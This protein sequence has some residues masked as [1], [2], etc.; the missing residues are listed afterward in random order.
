MAW[1]EPI[2]SFASG[3]LGAGGQHATNKAN[4]AI[5]REQMAFQERMSSTAAQRAVADYRAAGLN[6]ALAYDRGASS[7]SGASA[8][9]GNVAEAGTSSAKQT[10]Q[11]TQAMRLAAEEAQRAK[12]KHKSDQNLTSALT[13]KAVA[14]TGNTVQNTR[15]AAETEKRLQAEVARLMQDTKFA[16]ARQPYDVQL[17]K[18]QALLA[19]LQIPGAR[20]TAGFEE[21]MGRSGKGIS[22]ARS[23]AEI[24]KL[25]R[26]S[27]RD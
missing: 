16:M 9:M 22:V 18:A 12:E 6:P 25:L 2:A 20:N 11:L 17:A 8:V 23:A 1:W 19:A 21:L 26:G 15:V 7:P 4:L 14:E 10:A 13:H 3:L 24:I 5:A 27:S